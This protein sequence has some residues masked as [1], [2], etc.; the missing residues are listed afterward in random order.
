MIACARLVE[1]LPKP[2][3]TQVRAWLLRNRY[4]LGQRRRNRMILRHRRSEL[5]RPTRAPAS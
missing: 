3:T 4:G 5:C 2:A 1:C